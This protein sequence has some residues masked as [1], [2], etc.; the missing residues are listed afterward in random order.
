MT[1]LDAPAAAAIPEISG[2]PLSPVTGASA[3]HSTATRCTSGVT[4]LS[5][6]ASVTRYCRYCDVPPANAPEDGTDRNG[7]HESSGVGV[8]PVRTL[9]ATFVPGGV[10][11]VHDS[12]PHWF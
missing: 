10:D 11:A 1:A 3:C 6:V 2:P 9:K 5:V 12:A 4:A 7:V 8:G